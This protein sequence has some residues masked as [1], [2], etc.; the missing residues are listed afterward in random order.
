MWSKTLF[1]SFQLHLIRR[2]ENGKLY[3]AK[4]FTTRKM[5]EDENFRRNDVFCYKLPFYDADI[6]LRNGGKCKWYHST[7]QNAH[8]NVS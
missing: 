4:H 3:D 8:E 1:N 6:K 2:S 5:N 7:L